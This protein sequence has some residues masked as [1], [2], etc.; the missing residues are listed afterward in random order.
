MKI[1]AVGDVVSDPGCAFLR[2]R[3][4]ALKIEHGIDLCIA[5]GENS[6]VGNGITP[7]SAKYLFDSG[8]DFITTGNHAYRRKE[9]FDF[10]EQRRDIIRPA[11]FFDGCPG[12]GY[13]VIDMG[14]TRVL[15]INLAGMMFMENCEN[16]FHAVDRI[17]SENS[18]IKIKLVD[19]HAEA[20]AEKAAMGFYL[21][22]RVSAV[23]GTH[24]HI[25]TNDARILPNGTGYI[26]DLGM[27]GVVD[28]VIGVKKEISIDFFKT[29]MPARFDAAEGESMVNGCIFEIDKNTGRC[30]SFLP[31]RLT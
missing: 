27:T 8:V 15:V 1:F 18:D 30:L 31:V 7:F 20:T 13:S 10:F 12:R 4:P 11:N 17:L 29:G 24:T 22:G 26:T 3:L 28:S 16:P 5:N 25:M 21:D 6:A 9:M 23:F 19:F 2:R 14:F